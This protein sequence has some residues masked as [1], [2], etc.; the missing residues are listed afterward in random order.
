MRSFRWLVVLLVFTCVALMLSISLLPSV[1]EARADFNTWAN[2]STRV[3]EPAGYDV[4]NTSTCQICTFTRGMNL[5]GNLG[6]GDGNISLMKPD[7]L[8]RTLNAPVPGVSANET[9][10][11]ATPAYDLGTESLYP[12]NVLAGAATVEGRPDTIVI[13][14]PFPHIM[15]EAPVEAA[16]LY[17]KLVGLPLPDGSVMDVGVKSLGYEY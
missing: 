13:G 9:D 10:T 15:T 4:N 5:I 3:L 17:G 11:P 6:I 7:H 14:H 1:A 12:Q 16:A 8:D 2:R